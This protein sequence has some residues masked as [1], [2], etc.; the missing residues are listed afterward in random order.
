MLGSIDP[1]RYIAWAKPGSL[2]LEDGRRDEIV[3]HAAL[4]NVVHASP[5]DT[6]VRWYDAP[7]A[8]NRQAYR[9]AFDWL[10]KKLPIE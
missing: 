2:L 4:L 9:G 7:H 3:P 8:L 5:A 10:A 1:L 6:A